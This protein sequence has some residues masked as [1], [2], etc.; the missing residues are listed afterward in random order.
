MAFLFLPIRNFWMEYYVRGKSLLFLLFP[1]SPRSHLKCN[2]F[3]SLRIWNRKLL[4]YRRHKPLKAMHTIKTK[5]HRQPTMV[6]VKLWTSSFHS[7]FKKLLLLLLR[8]LAALL[9]RSKVDFG[10]RQKQP[11]RGRKAVSAQPLL[12]P[13][14]GVCL[15]A[16][17]R[18]C[19]GGSLGIHSA[20][21]YNGD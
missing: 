1:N 14:L 15:V 7:L 10:A 18:L 3:P 17:E 6:Q 9:V 13:V 16:I 21:Y 12:L 11:L 2:L 4:P 8:R 5:H 19:V 20:T